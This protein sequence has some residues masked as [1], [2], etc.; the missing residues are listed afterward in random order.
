MGD[1]QRVDSESTMDS[2]PLTMDRFYGSL[3][4]IGVPSRR[5]ECP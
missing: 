1:G 3:T 2:C 5:S 4:L